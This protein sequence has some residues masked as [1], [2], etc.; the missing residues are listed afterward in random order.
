MFERL[1]DA[2]DTS[3]QKK[4]QT[5]IDKLDKPGI[6]TWMQGHP[7]LDVEELSVRQ[8]YPIARRLQILNYS[9]LPKECLVAAIK[10]AE[11]NGS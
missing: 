10:K 4:V 7:S 6:Q 3:Q 8:L 2:S 9:R 1:W 5:Y 11:S